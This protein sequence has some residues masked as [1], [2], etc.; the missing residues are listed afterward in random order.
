[1]AAEAGSGGGGGAGGSEATNPIGKILE[2]MR[3]TKSFKKIEEDLK[4]SHNFLWR[5][6]TE[7]VDSSGCGNE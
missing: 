7:P 3:T 6:M 5:T 1:M 2:Q 4:K